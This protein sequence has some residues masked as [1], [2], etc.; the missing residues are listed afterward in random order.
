[1]RYLSLVL[2][3]ALWMLTGCKTVQPVTTIPVEEFRTLDT[4]V[5]S[6]PEFNLEEEQRTQEEE[7]V[8]PRFNASSTRTHDLL[9]TKLEVRFNWETEQVIGQATLKLKPHFYPS[10]E[11]TLDA[12]GFDLKQVRLKGQSSDLKYEYD[13]QQIVIDLGRK[14]TRKEQYELY[15]DYIATPSASGGSAAITSDKGLFFINPEGEG[16]KPQQIWTQGETEHNSRWFPT[17][18]KPNERCTQEMYVTVQDRFKTLSNGVLVNS[19]ANSDGTRTDYWNMDQ[20]HAPYLF[21]LTI[22]EFA[23]VQERWNDMLLEYYVEE[24]YREYAKDIFPYTPDMLSFFSDILGVKYPWQK[25]SQVVVRDYVSGAME[26]TTAVIFGE[27]MNGTKED[28]VDVLLNEKIVAHEMMHHWFGDYVTCE[29]WANLTMNEGFA[30]YSEYLWLEHKYGVDEAQY[31]W[32]QEMRGYLAQASS[33]IHPLIN[34]G[35]ADKEDMFDGHSYNKGGIVLHMLRQHVGDDAFFAS[36]NLYLTRNAYSEVEAD[37]LRLA[38]EDVT[39]EDLLWFFDQWFF[40]AG[41]PQLTVSHEYDEATKKTILN[42]AQTQSSDQNQP[43]IFQLPVA[44]DIY[45][46]SGKPVRKEILINQREQQF[47]FDMDARPKLVV[48]DA[49][50]SLLGEISEEKSDEEYVFQY[51]NMPN[52]L[53]RYESMQALAASESPMGK[54]VF[55]KAIKDKF[56]GLRS[57]ALSL[58]DPS[59][60]SNEADIVRLAEKDPHSDVR[61]SAIEQLMYEPD[62]KYMSLFERIIANDPAGTVKSSAQQGIAAIYA[63]GDDLGKLSFFEDNW[64]EIDGFDAISY[65]EFYQELAGKGDAAGILSSAKK[66]KDL[67]LASAS[68]WRRFGAMKAINGLHAKLVSQVDSADEKAQAF[69]DADAEVLSMIEAIKSAETDS[70]LKQLFINFP[71]P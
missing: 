24:E 43:A 6:A 21:M 25:Y 26:N 40:K 28:L 62:V 63:Q 51:N 46:A 29:S 11:L 64:E 52:F 4:L 68:Q 17:I 5:V 30:N 23:V 49:E 39:G 37:E 2:V 19:K 15:I 35:H 16:D 45:D 9:H 60:K 36:L 33:D 42:V 59:D 66:L 50:R 70:Q 53:D 20:P 27:F 7:Y 56:Y 67:A 55:K 54:Q 12:K 47:E 13:G 32:L 71:N 18:D 38:F 14:Y 3:M 22:G 44:I 48:F 69:T 31:H 58:L 41:H 65:L 1:M 34:Y 61:S 57:L 10:Q 8:L